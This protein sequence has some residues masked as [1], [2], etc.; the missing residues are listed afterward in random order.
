MNEW[1]IRPAFPGGRPRLRGPRETGRPRRHAELG[2]ECG[3]ERLGHRCPLAQ[4]EQP[5]VD[6]HAHDP[7]PEGL[8]SRAAQTAESTPPDS[9]QT[10]RSFGPDAPVDLRHRAVDERLHRPRAA[11][12]RRPGRESC[13]E[14]ASRTGVC[15]TSG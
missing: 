8:A 1:P 2:D 4:P 15:E 9:P 3:P 6:E 10:T 13:P 5:V 7:G 11:G 12:L 14:S